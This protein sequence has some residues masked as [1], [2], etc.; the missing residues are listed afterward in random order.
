M[1]CGPV[2]MTSKNSSGQKGSLKAMMTFMALH[3]CTRFIAICASST[4]TVCQGVSADQ[5]HH[6]NSTFL[7]GGMIAHICWR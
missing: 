6:S 1:L 4:T 3:I 2:Q 7:T 5:M